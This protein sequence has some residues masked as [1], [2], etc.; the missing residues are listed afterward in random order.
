M[1]TTSPG[2]ISCA[3]ILFETSLEFLQ[4]VDQDDDEDDED[5]SSFVCAPVLPSFPPIAV[6]TLPMRYEHSRREEQAGALA[7]GG[8]PVAARKRDW[9]VQDYFTL[10]LRGTFS[11]TAAVTTRRVRQLTTLSPQLCQTACRWT[12]SFSRAPPLPPLPPTAPTP[13]PPSYPTE[14]SPHT[15]L[16]LRQVCP[17]THTHACFS[18]F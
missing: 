3:A 12:P 13:G 5:S 6:E 2:I 14:P 7:M 15:H 18:L 16:H 17:S 8:R 1:T 4:N 10:R 9:A 11:C